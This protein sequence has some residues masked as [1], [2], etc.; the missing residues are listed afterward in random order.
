M[1]KQFFFALLVISSLIPFNVYA[2]NY[3]KNIRGNGHVVKETRSVRNFTG[4]SASSGINVF[5]FQGNENKVVVE[6]DENL[7]DCIVV[8][9]EGNTLRCSVNCKITRSKKFNVYVNYTDLKVIKATS[10]ADVYGETVI[11]T[12]Q[13]KVESSSGADVKVEVVAGSI[14]SNSSSGAGI[15]ITGKAGHLEANASSG[16]DIKAN[17]LVVNTC[18]A[19]ASSAGSITVNVTEKIEGKA[20]SGGDVVYYGNPASEYIRESSGG[21]VRR[22]Y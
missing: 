1:I 15:L 5:L 19:S 18:K 14:F 17:E 9:V 7:L 13:L 10:G 3:G 4:V 20:S 11:V 2:N 22:K 16:A 21:G 6:A 12:D 8:K